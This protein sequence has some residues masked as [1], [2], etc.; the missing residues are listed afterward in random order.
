M[1]KKY[2]SQLILAV[3]IVLASTFIHECGHYYFADKQGL[4]PEFHFFQY[5]AGKGLASFTHY[6]SYNIVRY[7]AVDSAE[8]KENI[9]KEKQ[10]L[11]AGIY[12][13]MIFVALILFGLL[14]YC[15]KKGDMIIYLG[16]GIVFAIVIGWL[17]Y[18]NIF[19]PMVGS[20]LWQMIH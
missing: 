4:D 19:N 10:M 13:E 11:F 3:I 16:I 14:I 20:D 17:Y 9:E 15:Y 6:V 18:W 5:E 8:Q 2:I 12:F 1:D 7:E